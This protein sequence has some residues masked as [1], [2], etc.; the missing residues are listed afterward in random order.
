MT[1]IWELK[2]KQKSF[3]KSIVAVFCPILN[4]TVYF[5]SSGL[6][7]LLYKDNR[8]PRNVAEQFMKLHCLAYAPEVIKNC[9]VISEIRKLQIKIKGIVK[10]VV[11]Y[12]LVCEVES[13]KKVRVIVEKVGTGKHRFLSTMKDGKWSK[14]KKHP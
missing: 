5:T 4:D 2:K 7:H 9:T 10:E 8:K 11:H 1:N 14:S 3:Y 6:Q 13:G 12:E